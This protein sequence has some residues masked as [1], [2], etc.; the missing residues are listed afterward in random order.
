MLTPQTQHLQL[1]DAIGL[2][3]NLYL[4]REDLH[5][6]GSHKGR[7]IPLMIK[8]YYGLC[9][10]NFCISSSGNAALAALFTIQQLN[11]QY[12]DNPCNLRIF[13]GRLISKEKLQRLQNEINDNRITIEQ[14]ETPKQKAFQL[15]KEGACKNLRQSI[16]DAALTGYQ[17]LANELAEISRSSEGGKNISAVFI[18]T[19]SGT[20]AQGLYLGFKKIGINPQI[21]IVQTPNCH[22]FVNS[23]ETG[24][25]LAGAI[26]DTV[27]YRK[28]EIQKILDE[29]NGRGWIA[30][31]SDI[32]EAQQLV[33]KKEN[34]E[35]SPNSALSVA[36]LQ[37][38]LNAGLRF[39]G[40]VVCLVT[41]K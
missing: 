12:P 18:P 4:K 8:Y 13:V 37:L 22:P 36:G 28:K 25:S 10:T 21:H 35:I 41:G 2:D 23:S 9:H 34:I 6:Y 33:Q 1:A 15:D 11:K 27:G 20:T 14:V 5:P 24:S 38:A 7:S 19:S 32:L 16:D 40:P 17:I 30:A 29:T 26:V 31:D 3:A 39:D